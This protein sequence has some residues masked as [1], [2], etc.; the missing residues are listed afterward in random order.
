MKEKIAILLIFF[1]SYCYTQLSTNPS[2]FEVNQSV[3]ITIDEYST[4]T[5]CNGFNSPNKV[6]MHSGIGN[7]SQPWGFSVIGNWGQDDGLG[8]MTNN[9][10][11]TWS[12]C[13]LYTSPS[14]RDRG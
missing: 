5:N 12:I 9:G 10:D 13:L 7:D 4:A 8:E 3:T 14:P 11:G 2:P 6:Y 1:S